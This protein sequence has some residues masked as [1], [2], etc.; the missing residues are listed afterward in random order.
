[1]L[2]KTLS[3]SIRKPSLCSPI[4]KK[5]KK[6]KKKNIFINHFLEVVIQIQVARAEVIL[7]I[8]LHNILL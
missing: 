3:C 2:I 5:K 8:I 4:N 1:M 7:Y 6:K